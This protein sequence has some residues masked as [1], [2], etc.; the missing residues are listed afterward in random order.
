MQRQTLALTVEFNG[1]RRRMNV[2][3][4]TEIAPSPCGSSYFSELQN[5]LPTKQNSCYRDFFVALNGSRIRDRAP[6]DFPFHPDSRR[7]IAVDDRGVPRRLVPHGGVER[8]THLWNGAAMERWTEPRKLDRDSGVA[9]PPPARPDGASPN[10]VTRGSLG[11]RGA[12]E[13]KGNFP[14]CKPLKYRKTAKYSGAGGHEDAFR[15]GL[16]VTEGASPKASRSALGRTRRR[17]RRGNFPGC[18][19]LKYHKTGK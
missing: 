14:A 7:P 3:T 12:E 17:K 5:F 6:R 16:T 18:K 19:P 11:R 15:R 8:I 1:S 2:S 4:S 10:A 13:R 9:E